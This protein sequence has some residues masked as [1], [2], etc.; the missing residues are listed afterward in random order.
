MKQ[1]KHIISQTVVN[2][3]KYIQVRA[4][5]A[6]KQITAKAAGSVKHCGRTNV[7]GVSV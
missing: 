4:Q 7:Y 2:G 3:V 5:K 6:P 1:S